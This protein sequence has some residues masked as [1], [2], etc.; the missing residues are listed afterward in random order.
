[1][2]VFEVARTA[3]WTG[4]ILSP[5]DFAYLLCFPMVAIS[6]YSALSCCSMCIE[7]DDVN[8]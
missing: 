1:M 6:E 8:G 2:F 3:F 5:F 4:P 7:T